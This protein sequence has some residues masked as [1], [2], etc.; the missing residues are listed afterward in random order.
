MDPP[1]PHPDLPLEIANDLLEIGLVKARRQQV[2]AEPFPVKAQAHALAG[3]VAV[4][5]VGVLDPLDLADR[6]QSAPFLARA[7]RVLAVLG[8]VL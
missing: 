7:P 6:S 3:Q 8:S 1:R 4:E 5:G 2:I